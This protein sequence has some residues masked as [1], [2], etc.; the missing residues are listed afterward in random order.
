MDNA[1]KQ[2]AALLLAVHLSSL[3]C[4]AACYYM[5]RTQLSPPSTTLLLHRYSREGRPIV[6]PEHLLFGNL[7]AETGVSNGAGTINGGTAM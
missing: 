6:D 5:D 4:S 1:C 2:L 3:P 7:T